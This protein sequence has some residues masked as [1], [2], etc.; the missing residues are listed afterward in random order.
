MAASKP[1][2][3]AA[4]TPNPLE[5]ADFGACMDALGLEAMPE[6]IAVAVSGGA[7][8]MAL[9]LL[10]SDWASTAGI[11]L[12]ALTV[13]HGIRPESARESRQVAGWMAQR[14]IA[15]T[16]LTHT[17]GMNGN[18]QAAA[19][20]ARYRLMAEWCAEQ[21]FSHLMLA[22]HQEDQ[23]ETYLIRLGRGSGVD[24]LSAMHPVRT[25]N[26]L[27]LLRP[28][29]GIP[30]AELL[31]TL[32]ARGQ[33]W[34]EDPS[35]R[36]PDFTRTHMRNLL[37]QL[38]D[39]G[40]TPAKLAAAARHMARAQD[41]LH[42]TA[43]AAC[44]ELL[45]PADDGLLLDRTRFAALHPEIALRVLALV[46]QRMTG[47]QYRPRFDDLQR[48]YGALCNLPE[49]VART[50]AGCQFRSHMNGV[51]LISKETCIKK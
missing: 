27:T 1:K 12:H 5:T 21:R 8:S 18:L 44:T 28:L 20:D 11:Q 31:A 38:A 39:A 7:D 22:H 17:G 43:D 6:K 15:H 4:L 16:I 34:L 26:G 36:N 13:D 29:L 2:P 50:L 30:K 41:F 32:Q 42:Q 9:A 14:G 51:L 33:F 35:N 45:T 46:I 40:I 48:L 37:P 23:A 25:Q 10:A 3:F 24:G 49:N 19:R 47:D